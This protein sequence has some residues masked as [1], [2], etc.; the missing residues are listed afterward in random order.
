MPK[1]HGMVLVPFILLLISTN[2]VS[3][4]SIV[5][6]FIDHD[7]VSK[8]PDPLHQFKLYNGTYNLGNKH[9]WASAAF[10]GI[11]GY[12]IAGIWLLFGLGFG[13]YMIYKY[14]HGN[15]TPIVDYPPSSYILMFLLVVLFTILAIVASSVILAAN[16]GFEHRVE[17][18][19]QTIFDAGGD[20]RQTIRRVIKVLLN[21]Q[22]V[23]S[24]YDSVANQMLNL[25]THRLRRGSIM[26]QQFVDKTR[27]SSNEAITSLYV[28]NIVVVT[29][30]LVF[31]VSALVLLVWHWPLG[32]I[33]IIFC[34]WILTTLN[35][36]LTGFDFF[37]HTFAEDTCSAL[38]DFQQNPKNNSLQLILPCAEAGTSD[39]ILVQIGSTVHNFISQLNS[40]LT[41]VQGLGLNDMGENNSGKRGI[42]DPFSGAPNFSFTPDLCP[43]DTI[44]I[45]ELKY[46]LSR[47]TCYGEN[48]TAN[49][50]GEGRF[51]PQ[52]SSMML[53]AYTESIQD[54]IE[55]FPDLLSLTQ[56]STVKQA[57]SNILQY[58][59][60]PFRISARILWS[61]M[62]SLSIIMV[63][64][65]LTW[66]VKAHQ[67]R[68]RNF[69][70]CSIV[71]IAA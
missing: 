35:W 55:I 58:Q 12:A 48:S 63:L 30:N 67:E 1:L 45:G 59:C 6:G 46:V 53:F 68:G 27:H 60:R 11:H 43:K 2:M 28:A 25:T 51:I 57:F 33:I 41:E 54:L 50:L 16:N 5:F 31:L 23:L 37:S 49:C 34:C 69:G 7:Q 62:L 14:F 17:R 18:L 8:R 21:M 20:T 40:K 42:C 71:P 29:V 44:P 26:I 4:K 13:S 15:S 32:F 52:A 66:I 3:Q 22:T 64:L 19:R 56:C 38:E 61:S 39:K 65:V 70:T 24:P 36:V 9:Y 47:V 10:T